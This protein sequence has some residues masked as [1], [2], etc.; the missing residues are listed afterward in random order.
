MRRA[1]EGALA[2]PALRTTL[3]SQTWPQLLQRLGF[4]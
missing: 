4:T 2:L 3:L 1:T